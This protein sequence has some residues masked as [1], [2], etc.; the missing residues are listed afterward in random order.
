MHNDPTYFCRVCGLDQLEPQY[1]ENGNMP[2]YAICSCCGVEF[3]Y[4][5]MTVQS[6]KKF[7][8]KWIREG[9]KWSISEHMPENWSWE[10]QK[11]SIPDAFR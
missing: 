9:M 7:R 5:D 10:E 11:K 8:E 2:T 4:G 3:G 1:G 6:A